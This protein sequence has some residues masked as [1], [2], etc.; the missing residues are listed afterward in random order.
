MET[1]LKIQGDTAGLPNESLVT[2]NC[3]TICVNRI[4]KTK[5]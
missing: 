1:L 2:S 3:G 4:Y 5:L